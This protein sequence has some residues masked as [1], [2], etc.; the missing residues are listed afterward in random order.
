[1]TIINQVLNGVAVYVVGHILWL[2][3]V[4]PGYKCRVTFFVKL[5][6][7]RASV[8]KRRFFSLFSNKTTPRVK[9]PMAR[10]R[11]LRDDSD[12]TRAATAPSTADTKCPT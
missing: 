4:P 5:I 7:L 10:V 6:I 1:M 11:V 3:F 2:D 12:E 8:C 9:K